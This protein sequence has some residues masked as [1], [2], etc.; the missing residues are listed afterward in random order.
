MESDNVKKIIKENYF[1]KKRIDELT[2]E[3]SRLQS[4]N[5]FYASITGVNQYGK[6]FGK[7]SADK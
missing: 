2:K 7:R 3:N 4:A 6:S 1:L 5:E